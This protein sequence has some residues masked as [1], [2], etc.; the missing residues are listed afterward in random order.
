MNIRDVEAIYPLSPLQEAMLSDSLLGRDLRGKTGQ[1]V[2]A[3][4]GRLDVSAFERAWQQV[5]D[6]HSILRTF[7]VWKRV[8]K[9]LQVA[10][11]H[12]AIRLAKQDWSGLSAGEQEERFEAFLK[13]D[14]E[15]QFDPSQAPPIRLT[16]CQTSD[17]EHQLVI[18]YHRM[19]LDDRSLHLIL[20]EAFACYEAY[21]QG[22]EPQLP[23]VES[24]RNYAAWIKAQDRSRSEAFWREE[25]AGIIAQTPLVDR[26]PANLSGQQ[27]AYGEQQLQIPAAE[28][29]ALH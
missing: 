27:G 26:V 1:W 5:A 9:P 4:Q 13:S 2:C 24:Y 6:R 3:L 19:A 20:K 11:K 15:Q 21:C 12:L 17:D 28:T 22:Q 25:L 10:H 7:F 23:P 14:R 18:S 16:L 8:E 29:A